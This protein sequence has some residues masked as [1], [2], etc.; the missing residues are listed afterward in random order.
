MTKVLLL[1]LGR[2]GVNHYP[3]PNHWQPAVT[4]L[5]P[6]LPALPRTEQIV[7]EILSLPIHSEMGLD[8]ADRVCDTIAEFYGR[9]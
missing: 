2:W 3:R 4:D 9:T 5:F 8:G 6:G 1:G 7:K